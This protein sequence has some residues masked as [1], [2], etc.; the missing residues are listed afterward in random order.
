[1][2]NPNFG[3]GPC[4]KRPAWSLD[5]LKDSAVGRSHRSALG[6]EKINL[7]VSETKRIL[8]IPA[9]YLVGVMP[10]SDTGAFEAAMWSLLGARPVTVLVW[11]SFSEGWAT[12]VA[13]QL[14]LTP[15]ILR[16]DYGAIPDL[17]TVN[18]EHDCVFVANG[19][20]SGVKIPDWD[21]IPADRKGLSLCDAT[22]A[23]FAMPIDWSKTDVATFSWQKCLGGEAAH[24][25]LVLAP[26]AV[27]RLESYDPPWPLPKIFRL[28]K[29]GKVNG[30][31]FEGDTIN[32]PSM[33]CV[34]DY[35]DALRWA[36]SIGLEGLIAR[37]REN[38]QVVEEWVAANDWIDFLAAA[39]ETR[40][41]TSVCLSVVG[42]KVRA[43]PK[44][45]KAKFLKGIVSEM[46]KRKAAYDIGS[47]RDAPP[48]FRFWCGPT[49]N[50]GDIRR[51][52]EE[53]GKV[54]REKIATL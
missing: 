3:S 54:Y 32:T 25:M 36:G 27:E 38:L 12:D 8:G 15:T 19:T 37:S 52:L 48:G 43:L 26:R 46:A 50:P 1:M 41:N 16:A 6:K 5:A 17:K 7:A 30:S 18:W 10:A 34:E 53:L 22:S 14:K 29:G 2:H 39:P 28:K 20:T 21:W 49:L 23:A 35:L 13:K 11:E 44:E 9:H 33:L 51:A 47:Y 40:S 31:I 42:A 24:G 45:E 4:S